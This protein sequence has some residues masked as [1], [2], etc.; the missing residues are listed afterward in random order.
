MMHKER[1]RAGIN[2]LL[3][4]PRE[5]SD[6]LWRPFN[7]DHQVINSWPDPGEAVGSEC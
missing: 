6:L 3:L 1:L 4:C 2:R 5:P 7:P